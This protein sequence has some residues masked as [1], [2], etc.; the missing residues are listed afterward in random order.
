MATRTTTLRSANG[1][2]A[3]PAALLAQAATASGH[4]VSIA[5]Q[6][7]S[8][9]AK[10]LLSLLGLAARHGDEIVVEVE[11]P[12]DERVA[13]EIAALLETDHDAA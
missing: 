13:A 9:N 1:L 12:D 6:D 4:T 8:A 2:H 11:G 10:S 7:R 3:R 5:V